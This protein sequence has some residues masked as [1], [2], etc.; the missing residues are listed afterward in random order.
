MPHLGD[1][2]SIWITSEHRPY[3]YVL[4]HFSHVYLFAILWTLACQ[5]SLSMGF[6]RQEY[7]SGLPFPSPGNLPNPGIEPGSPA[8]QELFTKWAT[9]GNRWTS[10]SAL[11]YKQ[12]KKKKKVFSK[13]K[14][15]TSVPSQEIIQAPTCH[16][17]NSLYV[18]K[19]ETQ[20][21]VKK[22]L[23]I[24]LIGKT[25][26]SWWA[27]DEQRLDFT[28]NWGDARAGHAVAEQNVE[29]MRPDLEKAFMD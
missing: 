13:E 22:E 18:Q 27:S 14:S 4:S 25:V 26:Y 9:K 21:T 24:F 8:L 1:N 7:W 3:I 29:G 2:D 12:A 10:K 16:W 17:L 15:G 28:W 23:G 19:G 20:A 11:L 6:S 5:A